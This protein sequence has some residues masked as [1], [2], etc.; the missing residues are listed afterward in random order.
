MTCI[1]IVGE[2]VTHEHAGI[3]AIIIWIRLRTCVVP[4][5]PLFVDIVIPELING[6]QTLEAC[7]HVTVQAVVLET[8]DAFLVVGQPTLLYLL[9]RGQLWCFT[10]FGVRT[11]DGISFTALLGVLLLLDIYFLYVVMI[12][13]DCHVLA[14]HLVFVSGLPLLSIAAFVWS[15]L[16][17]MSI[18]PLV[19]HTL[20]IYI[21][22]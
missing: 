18:T 8:D 7:I 20:P 4:F 10:S 13:V 12:L 9:W 1:S 6:K 5:V 19:P 14:A 17:V 11:S 16:L 21:L 3:V 22:S 15:F 2:Y